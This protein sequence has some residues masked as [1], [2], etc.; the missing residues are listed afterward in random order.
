ML[1][2]YRRNTRREKDNLG[3]LD[4]DR[5]IIIKTKDVRTQTEF[6]CEISDPHG[7]KFEDVF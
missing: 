7:S 1:R 2:Y 3:D 5:K 4:I 6:T